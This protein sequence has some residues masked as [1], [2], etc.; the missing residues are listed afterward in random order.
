MKKHPNYKER[1]IKNCQQCRVEMF[2]I[3]ARK[4]AKFCSKICANKARVGKSSWNKGFKGYLA[5]DKHYNWKGGITTPE[6]RLDYNKKWNRENRLRKNYLTIT[7]FLKIKN[8]EGSHT[9]EQWESLVNSFGGMCLCCK[10]SEPEITLTE[11]HI[12]P[13]SKGGSNNIDNIQPLCRSCNSRKHDRH[14][15]YLSNYQ[16]RN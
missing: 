16:L 10:R 13:I 7:R 12:I 9:F 1:I 15:D 6:W 3:P 8:I 11:D 2:L 5:G 14:I 4:D